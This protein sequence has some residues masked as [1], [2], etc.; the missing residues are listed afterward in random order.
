MR[1]D[2]TG[3]R[4]GD[5][6]VAWVAAPSTWFASVVPVTCQL[7]WDVA[8]IDAPVDTHEHASASGMLM[9]DRVYISRRCA[10]L[11]TSLVTTVTPVLRL[12]RPFR[13]L[14]FLYSLTVQSPLLRDEFQHGCVAFGGAG[15]R[16]GSGEARSSRRRTVSCTTTTQTQLHA[17]RIPLESILI[18]HC[19]SPCLALLL[20][21]QCRGGYQE[22]AGR[23]EVF[24]FASAVLLGAGYDAAGQGTEQH[25]P[26]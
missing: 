16:V 9:D 6:G 5:M 10:H 11:P 18:R 2:T 1:R 25:I 24:A 20:C 7:A 12:T 3:V 4:C 13:R 17:E 14:C 21:P 22:G 15:S 26:V 23:D 19:S 8:D